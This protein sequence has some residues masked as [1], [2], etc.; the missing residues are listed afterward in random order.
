V[1][2]GAE[3][4]EACGAGLRDATSPDEAPEIPGLTQVDPVVR[5][6]RP[7]ARPNRLVGWLADVDMEPSVSD[8]PVPPTPDPGAARAL[9]GAGKASF[10]PPTEEVRREMRRL[11]LEALQ[12]R[13]EARAAEARAA[14]LDRPE[15]AA[16]GTEVP[17]G[18]AAAA[19]EATADEGQAE[20]RDDDDGG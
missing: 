2:A 7:L 20:G 1:A 16:A 15:G 11:E 5:H 6:R 13:L 18:A 10:A 9:E 4:C 8:V 17:D 12:A 19:V 14:A 3:R